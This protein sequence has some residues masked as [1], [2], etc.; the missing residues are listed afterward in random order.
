MTDAERIDRD[1]ASALLYRDAPSWDGKLTAAIGSVAFESEAA[2][3]RL[4]SELATRLDAEGFEAVIG[5]MD[6]DTWHR[7]RLVSDSDGSAPFLLEPTSGPN[8]HAA[9]LAAGFRPISSYVSSRAL[10]SDTIG[11][12][13]VSM[14]GV[15]VAAW[16]GSD[17]E[18][19]IGKLF[20]MSGSAFA[21]NRFF[22]PITLEAF[23]SLY[24]PLLPLLD[25]RHILF[26]HGSAGEL[27]GFLFGMPDRAATT[28]PPAAILKTYASRMRGVGYLLADAYHRRAID[29]GF[30]EVIHALMHADNVSRQR[31]ERHNARVF[32]RYALMGRELGE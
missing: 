27:V 29:L 1:G 5:P 18:H 6:G 23:V 7:Y 13:P 16:D 4:L 32:R 20:E 21:G 12:E 3:G 30:T 15:T 14:T 11:D 24:R 8:D 25:P 28:A 9:F 26:A 31:S 19:L 22:K 17:A 10:L 2:G